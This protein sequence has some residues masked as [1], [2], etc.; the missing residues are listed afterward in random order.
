M[1]NPMAQAWAA[2]HHALGVTSA[3]AYEVLSGR[4]PDARYEIPTSFP[5]AFAPD[6][7]FWA[8][9]PFRLQDCRSVGDGSYYEST[10][11][12]GG[13]GLL[14][15]TLIGATALG[16][17]AANRRRRDAAARDMQPR[18]VDI[19]Q[20]LLT[21]GSQGMYLQ[22]ASGLSPWAWVW[23]TG[24]DMVAPGCLHFSGQTAHGTVSLIVVSDWAE[25]AFVG[26]A[27]ARHLRH[28]QVLD[29]SWYPGGWGPQAVPPPDAGPPRAIEP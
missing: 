19:D 18:W 28:R 9:G 25:L 23:I 13:T 10:T 6:E 12:V 11:I 21:V 2:R 7:R 1:S 26:W 29:G 17:A 15:L 5:P 22:S 20:G 16:S 14:G 8:C 3:I 27:A 4:M 24:A